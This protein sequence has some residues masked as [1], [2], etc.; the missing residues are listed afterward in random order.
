MDRGLNVCLFNGWA[1]VLLLHLLA[2]LLAT[3]F[4]VLVSVSVLLSQSPS[5][6]L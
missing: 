5:S 1:A 3:V 6:S 4:I 2:L